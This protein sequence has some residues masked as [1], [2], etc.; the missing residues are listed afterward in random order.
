MKPHL[1][2]KA[3]LAATCALLLAGS[4]AAQ[5]RPQKI[6]AL[7][8]ISLPAASAAKQSPY[9]EPVVILVDGKFYDASGYMATPR[10]LALDRGTVYEALN[11][12]EAAGFFTVQAAR[13]DKGFWYG[14]GEWLS[15]AQITAAKA[16]QRERTLTLADDGPPVLRKPKP[17]EKPQTSAPAPS[18]RRPL[19]D[20]P[21]RPTLRRGSGQQARAESAPPDAPLA[22]PAAGTRAGATLIAV[23]D[24]NGTGETRSFLFPWGKEEQQMLKRAMMALAEVELV[25]HWA[26]RAPKHA[27][28]PKLISAE[29][30]A[31]DLDLDNSAELVLTGRDNRSAMITLA[32]RVDVH[33][34]PRKM[35]ASI[36]DRAHLD[37]VPDLQLVGAVD[38]DGDNKGDLLFRLVSDSGYEYALYRVRKDQMWKVWE[39]GGRSH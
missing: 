23:S 32:A 27:P 21:E 7:A 10:P 9:L 8:V 30:A 4:A 2:R 20:D 31:F 38:A 18:A 24:P 6:R 15:A 29:V 1:Y 13:Q 25:K 3:A 11:N 12:G 5:T 35:M 16:E 14:T 17:D 33:Q 39:G 28:R 22:A 26:A 37:A 19:A 36:T 34:Q